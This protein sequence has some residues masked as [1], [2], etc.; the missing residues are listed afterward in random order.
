[1]IQPR[2]SRTGKVASNKMEGKT[3]LLEYIYVQMLPINACR[4]EWVREDNLTLEPEYT[5]P[6]GAALPRT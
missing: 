1:M 3:R 4:F 2:Q 5:Q 6:A